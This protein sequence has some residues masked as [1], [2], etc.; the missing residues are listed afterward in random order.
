MPPVALTASVV[1]RERQTGLRLACDALEG[2][3]EDPR[4]NDD[5]D[6]REA[7]AGA[8][9]TANETL[10]EEL[11]GAGGEMAIVGFWESRDAFDPLAALHFLARSSGGRAVVS[12]RAVRDVR[13]GGETS[14]RGVTR[15]DDAGE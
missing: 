12:M 6:A 9:R 14:D 1:K 11:R 15:G 10:L 5:G 13:G 2:V 4:A 8:K 3:A 7:N